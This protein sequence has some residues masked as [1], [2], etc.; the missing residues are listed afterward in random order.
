M[1]GYI[2]PTGNL[3]TRGQVFVK[4]RPLPIGRLQSL[5]LAGMKSGR[6]EKNSGARRETARQSTTDDNE[7][8]SSDSHV[9]FPT[10]EAKTLSAG[11]CMTRLAA[12][13]TKQSVIRRADSKRRRLI[14]VWRRTAGIPAIY[15]AA[16]SP[17]LE[18]GQ[19]DPLPATGL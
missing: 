8:A 4:L 5:S 14:A 11:V 9:T 2:Q 13:G 15:E 3:F 7:A 1:N 12:C 6:V 10:R 19:P 18:R 17:T 16:P